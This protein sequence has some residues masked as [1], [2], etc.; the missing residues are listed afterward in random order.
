MKINMIYPLLASILLLPLVKGAAPPAN[1]GPKTQ[2]PPSPYTITPN[3]QNQNT[4][5][6]LINKISKADQF[7]FLFQL[8]EFNDRFYLSPNGQAA[9]DFIFNSA[10]SLIQNA[11]QGTTFSVSRFVHSWNNQPSIIARLQS[12]TNPGNNSG[13]II[14]GSHFDTVVNTKGFPQ[15]FTNPAADDCA[16]GS[17][18]VYETMRVLVTSG[19]VPQRPIEF[20]WYGAE[21]VG[22]K[23]SME[24]SD[25]YAKAGTKVVSYLNLDQSG[26]V[27]PGTTPVMGVM[28]DF[29]GA[30]STSLLKNVIASYTTLSFVDAKCGY[31]CSDHASWTAHGYESA[32]AF[33][34]SFNDNSPHADEVSN[35]TQVP[36]I[37]TIEKI[38]ITHAAEFVKSSLGF[39]VELSLGK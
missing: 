8:T 2:G 17:S 11:P 14:M 10:S 39:V 38:N 7:Q 13:I 3:L 18:V 33:E 27:K 28:T 12:N 35:S 34:S 26:Y 32:L 23:G 37:D 19:F 4:V 31:Q 29:V 30:K 5:V 15:N 25:A 22:L 36:Q 16:S 24:V 21:E 20:H 1:T 9:S 6:N